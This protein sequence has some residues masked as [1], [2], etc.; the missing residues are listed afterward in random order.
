MQELVFYRQ[1][2]ILKTLYIF[3]IATSILNIFLDLLFV[4]GFGMGVDGAA[5]AT[6]ISE[7]ISMLLVINFVDAYEE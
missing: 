4:K 7:C 3:L 5:L 6:I 1:L 2:V